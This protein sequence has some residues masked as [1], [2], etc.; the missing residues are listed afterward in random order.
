MPLPACCRIV[1]G[2]EKMITIPP[3]H[4][5]VIE[6][7]VVR[8]SDGSVALDAAG[9][10]VLLHADLEIRTARSPF[11]LYPGE[12]LKVTVTPLT[13][14]DANSALRLK[15]VLD[16]E[17]EDGMKRTAGDEWLFEGPGEKGRGERGGEGQGEGEREGEG[18][19]R[20]EG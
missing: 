18:E 9:Q 14:V 4:Y 6:N 2:P 1:F 10:A 8:A 7:P 20:G 12:V 19:G 17:E 15:A 13:V 5:C 16:F 3:R 11:P